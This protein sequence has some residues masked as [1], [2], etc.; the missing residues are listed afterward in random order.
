[1]VVVKIPDFDR[2]KIFFENGIDSMPSPLSLTP[3]PPPRARRPN[4]LH[5]S[6]LA[7]TGDLHPPAPPAV[8]HRSTPPP[9][10]GLARG[11]L[12]EPDRWI[13]RRR[14]SEER[15]GRCGPSRAQTGDLHPPAPPAMLHRSPPP[16][17]RRTASK[18]EREA[19]IDLLCVVNFPRPDS[20]L[21]LQVRVL[22]PGSQTRSSQP[23]ATREHRYRGASLTRKRT[24]LGP[25]S[26][27]MPR[28]LGGL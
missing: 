2:C 14:W 19:E 8:L 20:G 6:R 7:Q 1:M 27:P 26:R 28:V 5:H 18:R 13:I 16:A 25:Y 11:R 15:A 10:R 4:D 22:R 17:R 9:H 12:A 24:P 3:L 23:W 21:V